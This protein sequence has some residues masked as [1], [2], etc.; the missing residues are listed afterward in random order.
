V[1]DDTEKLPPMKSVSQFCELVGISRPTYYRKKRE[2]DS[3]PPEFRIGPRC[4]RIR[5]SDIEAWIASKAA[6]SK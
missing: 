1:S 5:V 4:I 2:G 6:P 3:L